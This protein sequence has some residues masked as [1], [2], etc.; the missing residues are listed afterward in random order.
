[1]ELMGI[2]G[3]IDFE[4]SVG[5]SKFTLSGSAKYLESKAGFASDATGLLFLP[6]FRLVCF[7]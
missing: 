6:G 7:T 1:M 4:R 3:A 2:D 5:I